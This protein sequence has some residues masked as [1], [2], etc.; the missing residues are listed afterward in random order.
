LVLDVTNASLNH[1]MLGHLNSSRCSEE[2]MPFITWKSKLRAQNGA[3]NNA[4][5]RNGTIIYI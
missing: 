4:L 3:T 1:T 5:S 2:I